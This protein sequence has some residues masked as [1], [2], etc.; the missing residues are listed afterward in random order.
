[1]SYCF[2]VN[3]NNQN[4]PFSSKTF[5][6]IPNDYR[7]EDW[8]RNSG[9]AKWKEMLDTKYRL[10]MCEDHFIESDMSRQFNRTLVK[11]NA[12][13]IPFESE[14]VEE[15]LDDI[16]ELEICNQ[17]NDSNEFLLEPTQDNRES[18]E[19]VNESVV[20]NNDDHIVYQLL[21]DLESEQ[22][23]STVLFEHDVGKTVEFVVEECE[24]IELTDNNAEIENDNSSKEIS[25]ERIRSPQNTI[26]T[27]IE[28]KSPKAITESS[29]T[30]R[31]VNTNRI[32]SQNMAVQDYSED[33]H[34]VLSLVGPLQR[35]PSNVKPLIKLKILQ[36]ITEAEIKGMV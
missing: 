30:Q 33:E 14:F 34:F 21:S 25:I 4:K 27:S 12:I 15:R 17:D 10:C 24:M 32:L 19:N 36:L 9:N 13:P 8:L 26:E 2:Y 35:I 23:D 16:N 3:C 5:F 18:Q 1:M 7:R 28:Q 11:R 22:C 20:S 31:R 29:D 6:T